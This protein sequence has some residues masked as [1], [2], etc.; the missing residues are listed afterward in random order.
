MVPA[1]RNLRAN[2]EDM[3]KNK[4]RLCLGFPRKESLYRGDKNLLPDRGNIYAGP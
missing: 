1:P 4:E 3:Y 2:R